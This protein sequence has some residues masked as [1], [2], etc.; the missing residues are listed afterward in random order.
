MKIEQRSPRVQ[1]S[2]NLTAIIPFEAV[3]EYNHPSR[4]VQPKKKKKL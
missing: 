4:I 1:V 3:K 2:N